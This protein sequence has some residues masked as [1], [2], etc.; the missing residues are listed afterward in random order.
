ML[1][2]DLDGGC[3]PS[4]AAPSNKGR[5]KPAHFPWRAV[6]ARRSLRNT[7][8]RSLFLP[9]LPPFAC[10]LL[11]LQNK[12]ALRALST[13]G[14]SQDSRTTT[15]LS[16]YLVTC[17]YSRDERRRNS[18][19]SYPERSTRPFCTTTLRR[20]LKRTCQSNFSTDAD[21]S[22]ESRTLRRISRKLRFSLAGSSLIVSPAISFSY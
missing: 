2:S 3:P 7:S 20:P 11:S 17:G 14:T 1:A 13:C 8:V 15:G 21:K 12:R 16:C 19:S 5:S 6:A 10:P 4:P 18:P 22:S 9:L